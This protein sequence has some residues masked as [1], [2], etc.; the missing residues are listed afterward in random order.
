MLKFATARPQDAPEFDAGLIRLWFGA[1]GRR[2]RPAFL[3]CSTRLTETSRAIGSLVGDQAQI[4]IEPGQNL[5]DEFLWPKRDVT[6]FEYRVALVLGRGSERFEQWAL[7][8]L[9]WSLEIVAPVHHEGRYAYARREVE[10]INLGRPERPESGSL[11]HA[12]LEPRLEH[13]DDHA[14]VGTHTDAVKRKPITRVRETRWSYS[15]R[16]ATIGSMVA[17]RLAG[18]MVATSAASDSN[19][20]AATNARGSFAGSP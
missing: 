15:A 5:L 8:R 13:R 9:H 1:I 14:G 7:R 6:A 17:A 4:S 10:R 16:R 3:N 2:S 20:R 19:I 12:G 18:T 11:Q